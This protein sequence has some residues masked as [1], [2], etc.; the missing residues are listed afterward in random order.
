MNEVVNYDSAAVI[1]T[2]PT[3]NIFGASKADLEF[4]MIRVNNETD[5]DI[6]LSFG[7]GAGNNFIAKS[8]DNIL[9]AFSCTGK[10]ALSAASDSTGN[11]FIQLTKG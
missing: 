10:C 8:G 11:L 9:Q 5:K 6:T 7:Y 1:G 4:N 2:T 3:E